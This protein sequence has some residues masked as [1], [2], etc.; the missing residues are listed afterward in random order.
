LRV[1]GFFKKYAVDIAVVGASALLLSAGA[2]AVAAPRQDGGHI[3]QISIESKLY[4]QIDL[5]QETA[6]R[7]FVIQGKHTPLTI[8]VKT[9]AIAI[10]ESGCPNQYCV[11]EGWI[12]SSGRPL[13]CAYNEVLIE[14]QGGFQVVVQ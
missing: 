6:E 12:S 5:A 10:L 4:E 3:A 14:I 11:N 9:N 7:T 1:N 13:V 8:A 2:V